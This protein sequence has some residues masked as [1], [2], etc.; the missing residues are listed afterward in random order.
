MTTDASQPVEIETQ[1]QTMLGPANEATV[2]AWE[3][4]AARRA[5]RN[6]KTLLHGERMLEVLNTQIADQDARVKQIVAASDGEFRECRVDVSV[7]GLSATQFSGATSRIMASVIQAATGTPSET[8]AVAATLL[9][10]HPEHYVFP[11]YPGIVETIGGH[12]TRLKT[13][14]PDDLPEIVMSAMSDAYPIKQPG[15]AE[16]DDGTLMA[17]LLHQFR[18]TDTGCEMILRVWWPAAAPDLFF[19]EHAEHFAVEF[20]NFIRMAAT[21]LAAHDGA[22]PAEIEIQLQ[23]AHGPANEVTVDA[24]ELKA[25][26]RALLNLKMLL[27]GDPMLDLLKEQVDEADRVDSQILV[28]SHGEFRECRVDVSVKG[29]SLAGYFKGL[30]AYMATLT[31]G[32]PATGAEHAFTYSA[33]PEHY[34]K[35]PGIGMIET[36]GGRPTRMTGAMTT[37]L[38]DFAT[39]TLDGKYL[40]RGGTRIELEGGVVWAWVLHQFRDTSDGCEMILRVWW[41]AAAPEVYFTDHS[42]HFAVEFRNFIKM[43]ARA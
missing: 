34:V 11:P 36:I 5:L 7:T 6:L 10:T 13:L 22:P 26:R 40:N 38:P 27:D 23:T 37:D 9:A 32:V 29:Q 42:Q 43:P 2:D 16:L 3:L 20:R 17:W 30:S 25:A 33:H 1:F 28:D 12:P 24:W 39:A 21:D 19:D 4:K 15:K 18:D 31:D 8:V 41:P 35:L 14:P